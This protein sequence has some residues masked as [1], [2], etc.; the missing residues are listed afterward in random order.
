MAI[1]HKEKSQYEEFQKLQFGSNAGLPKLIID[2]AMVVHKKISEA[3]TFRDVTVMGL[4]QQQFIYL[5]VLIIIHDQLKKSLLYFL[6]S[7]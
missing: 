2:E 4:L 1:I 5:A 7:Y 6:R 3:K